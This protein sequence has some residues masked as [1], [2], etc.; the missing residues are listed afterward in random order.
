MRTTHCYMSVVAS[1]LLSACSLTPDM[2]KPAL[3]VA[4]TYTLEAEHHAGNAADLG[5]RQM[6]GDP[7]LQRLIE[8]GLENNRDLRIATLNVEAVQAQYRIEDSNRRP[9]LNVA[10][11]AT[12]QRIPANETAI[13]ST[14]GTVQ[15]QFTAG[16]GVSAFEIDF[17]GRLRSLSD[18]AFA[19]YLATAEGKRAAQINLIS[20]IAEVYLAERLATEQ[21]QLTQTIL[22]DWQQSLVLAR[23]LKAAYQASGLEVAQAEAQAA[24]AESDLEARKRLQEQTRNM[25]EL[26]IGIQTP[27]DLV[28]GLP[29]EQQPI[30]TQLPPGLPSELLLRR[31]DILQAEQS[32]IAANAEIGA[33]R[34]AFFPRLSLTASLGFASP[35]V[36]GLFRSGQ[37]VWSFAPQITQPIFQGGRL[38][39]ELRLAEIR[40]SVAIAQYEQVIQ[41]AFRD[42]RDG[43][44]GSATFSRQIA[45]QQRTADANRKRQQLSFLRYRAGQDSRLELLDAQRQY[46]ASKQLLLDLHRDE[47]RNAVALYKALGGGLM[48]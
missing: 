27:A 33:A 46:Y 38:R 6:F 19:R 47:F 15:N 9:A 21:L 45:A 8:L 42:V 12:R 36:N 14:P 24:T 18:A 39:A 43:L 41:S 40:K 4:A 26:L 7:R 48:E 22:D 11:G 3:P 30:L 13:T 31:P 29:L 34:A 25:L 23:H 32:L 1:I 20:A 2:V 17:F 16:L 37:S 44:A 5:W 28:Q 10:G 35:E